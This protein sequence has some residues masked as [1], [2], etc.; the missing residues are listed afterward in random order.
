[1]FFKCYVFNIQR[2][3]NEGKGVNSEVISI[4]WIMCITSSGRKNHRDY[5]PNKLRSSPPP[6]PFVKVFGFL[7]YK[8]NR[9]KIV[10]KVLIHL[11]GLLEDVAHSGRRS[12]VK[13]SVGF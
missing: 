11:L 6:F 2:K 8:K 4:L 1:M 3:E 12:E 10:M 5:R 9:K 7:S 13:P